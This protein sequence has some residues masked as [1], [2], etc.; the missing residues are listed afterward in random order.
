MSEHTPETAPREV[1]EEC[2]VKWR[3][4]REKRLEADRE[5]AKLKKEEDFLKS[6]VLEAFRQQKFEGMLIGSRI[7][8]LS[9]KSVPVVEDKAAFMEYIRQTGELDLLQFRIS[10]P[11]IEAREEDG[12]EI[13]GIGRM[14][15]Y[16]L[17]DRKA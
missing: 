12:Q 9:T 6:F 17:F 10:N 2:I 8:G 14:D 11:A 15:I 16:D 1:V 3:D 7:T 5:A 4:M 13:P